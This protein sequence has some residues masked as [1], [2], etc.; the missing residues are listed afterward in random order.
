MAFSS[1]ENQ[2][3]SQLATKVGLELLKIYMLVLREA[4]LISNL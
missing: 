2:L 3:V 1:F 4:T